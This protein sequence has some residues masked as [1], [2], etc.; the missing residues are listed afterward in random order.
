[1]LGLTAKT[2]IYQATTSELF[3]LVQEIPQKITTPFYPRSPYGVAKLYASWITVNYSEAYGIYGCNGILFNHELPR[4]GDSFVPRKI[5][6]A[7]PA[8]TR[9]WRTAFTWAT[10]IHYAI[11]AMRT[12]MVSYTCPGFSSKHSSRQRTLINCDGF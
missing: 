9:G 12:A 10:S 5:P 4:R 11:W 1:M 8:S 6:V 7:W 2:G 3:G